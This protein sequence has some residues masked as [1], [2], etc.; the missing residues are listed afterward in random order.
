MTK[1]EAQALERVC[2]SLM[3]HY[4]KEECTV[5]MALSGKLRIAINDY[6]ITINTKTRTANYIRFT[7][8]YEDLQEHIHN[9]ITCITENPGVFDKLIWS[10]EHVR[11]LT[12][13]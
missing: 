12:E 4:L 3:S 7:G 2:D 11:E 1:Q 5:Y 9:A 13:E 6:Y 8:F 10:Y